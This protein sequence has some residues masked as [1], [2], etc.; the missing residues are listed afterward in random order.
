MYTIPF[1]PVAG[2]ADG[3]EGNLSRGSVTGMTPLMEKPV[4]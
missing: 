4:L 1:I 3:F 2:S